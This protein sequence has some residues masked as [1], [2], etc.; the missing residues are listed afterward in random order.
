MRQTLLIGVVF[1]TLLH[2]TR[3]QCNTAR[4]S[5]CENA[6]FIPGSD[7]AGEGF[8]I[9]TMT[10]K[11]AFVIDMSIWLRK[12][13][14]CTLCKNTNMG[15]KE[16]KLPV[17]VLDW[18]PQTCNMKLSSSVYPS[19]EDLI[20]S[21][22]SSIENSWKSDLPFEVQGSVMLAGSHSKLAEYSMKK[23]KKDKF[24]FATH[25]VSCGYYRYRVRSS[26]V[27]HPEL[28]K[29]LKSL[30]KCYAKP[31]KQKYFDLID[32]FGTHYFRQVTLGGEVR[33]VTSIKECRASLQG[34]SVDEVKMCLDIEATPRKGP[35]V[36]QKNEANHC[37]HLKKNVLNKKSFAYSFN[38]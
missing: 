30:P 9:T 2:P 15:G 27:L 1:A 7:L 13:K 17:S 6:E 19:S 23:T 38:D 3:Q 29:E 8:D 21:S 20:N 24:S 12:D 22:I 5:E 14:T 36:D 34:L 4:E 16:Q 25:S 18:R 33:S 31:T 35:R 32:K 37:N 28:L 11:G 26:P 10:R